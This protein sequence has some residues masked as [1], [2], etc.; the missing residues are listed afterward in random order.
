MNERMNAS[1]HREVACTILIDTCGHFLFQQRDDIAGILHPGKV[2][3]FGGHR[4]GAETLLKCVVRELHEELSYFVPAV[5]FKYLTSVDGKDID[6][7]SGSFSG[8]L[9]IARD[10]RV[11]A[12]IITEGSLS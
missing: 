7:D 5:R 6:P 10:I 12:L 2:G 8:D 1:L 11:E 9:S 3:L 4:E